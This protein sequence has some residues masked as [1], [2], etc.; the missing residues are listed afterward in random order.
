MSDKRSRD[1]RNV[2]RALRKHGLLLMHDALLPSVSSL[3]AG[4]AVRGSWWA[5]PAS[6][7]IYHVE[8][9][10]KDH[11]DV[12]VVKLVSGK[13]TFVHRRHWPAL[14][15]L[16]NARE[17]WQ[18]D[19]LPPRARKL[20]DAVDASSALR[21]DAV[22]RMGGP[23]KDSP[24]EAARELERRLL[25]HAEEMHTESGAHYKRLE[26]W[27]RWARRAGATRGRMTVKQAKRQ[28]EEVLAAQIASSSGRG[29]LPWE[30][31]P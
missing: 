4:E 15:A 30:G 19:G 28:L 13:D 11:A 7:D 6:H 2:L 26:T 5:H 8:E 27:R 29:H 23:K 10:L 17:P 14:L 1:T 3:V 12:V 9:E 20:L 16:A 21:T 22:P 31:K 18:L 25:V 24:G